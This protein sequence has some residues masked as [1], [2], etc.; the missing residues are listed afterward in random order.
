MKINICNHDCTELWDSVLY[1]RLS[2]YPNITDW[3]MK[4]VIDFINYEK[5]NGRKTEIIS[6]SNDIMEKINKALIEPEKYSNPNKP[7][8]I[9]ECTACRYRKGCMTQF[10][11]HTAPLEN[12]IKIFECGKLLSAVNA[13]RLPAEILAKEPRNATND[14]EDFFHYVMFTW[15]NCQ[16]GDR[17]VMERK[18]NRPPTDEDMG[19]NLTPGIRFY[20]EYEKLEKHPNAIND[21]FIPI[22]VKDEV[23]LAD[24]VNAIII[25]EE[26]Q[27]IVQEIIPNELADR[28]YYIK[29]DCNDVWDWSE[30]VYS[31]VEKMKTMS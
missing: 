17:L 22:K 21:G 14:P 10:V 12:A 19:I 6:Y 8:K 15:G 20:F 30:K 23:V 3:E 2:N 28:T 13:R 31:F 26:Y 27:K 25:P 18:M 7:K 5:L 11:C 4:N 29:N 9:T 1:K 16:A 24:Y